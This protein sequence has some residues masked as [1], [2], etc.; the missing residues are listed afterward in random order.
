MR[1]K[2]FMT[3]VHA[4]SGAD[5]SSICEV[6]EWPIEKLMKELLPL[7]RARHGKGGV[8]VCAPCVH[9]AKAEADRRRGSA[10]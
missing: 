8:N 1:E 7:M 5:P 4:P 2:L 9:R 6:H 10:T 3:P